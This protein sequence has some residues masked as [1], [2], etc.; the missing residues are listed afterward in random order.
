MDTLIR[1]VLG[2]LLW[3]WDIFGNPFFGNGGGVTL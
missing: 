3:V 1:E 2:G